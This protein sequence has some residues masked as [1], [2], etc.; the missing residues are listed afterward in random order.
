MWLVLGI[1]CLLLI[2]IISSQMGI[3]EQDEEWANELR[4]KPRKLEE[5]K[6]REQ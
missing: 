3:A 5:N 1:V 2:F 4:K 6:E